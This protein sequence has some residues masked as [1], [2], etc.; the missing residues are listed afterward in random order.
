MLIILSVIFILISSGTLFCVLL[1]NN[2]EHDFIHKTNNNLGTNTSDNNLVNT[3]H[4]TRSNDGFK[5]LE[6]YIKIELMFQPH[7]LKAIAI[8]KFEAIEPLDT[9]SLSL[10]PILYI[11]KINDEDFSN[12]S[13]E[14]NYWDIEITLNNTLASGNII[15]ITIEYEGIIGST[16]P[17]IWN[18]YIGPEGIYLHNPYNTNAS[19]FP[20]NGLAP[21]IIDAIVPKGLTVVC[22]G[23]LLGVAHFTKSSTFAWA[24]DYPREPEV[25][26]FGGLYNGYYTSFQDINISIYLL[27]TE[28][29]WADVLISESLKIL[30]YYFSV[31]SEL[32]IPNLVILESTFQASRGYAVDSYIIIHQQVFNEG[33][34]SVQFTVSHEISHQWFG[35][36]LMPVVDEPGYRWLLEGFGKYA[37]I[38]YQMDNNNSRK[39]LNASIINYRALVNEWL[40][41]FEETPIATTGFEGEEAELIVYG[42]GS[43]VLHMLRYL[44]GDKM[45]FEILSTYCQNFA[46]KMVTLEDF[47]DISKTV[48]Q[49]DLDWFFEQ[50]IYTT[51][52]LDYG[53]KEVHQNKEGVEYKTEVLIER[54]DEAI[55]P[56]D[57]TFY[58]SNNETIKKTKVWNG[59]EKSTNIEITTE[60]KIWKVELDSEFWLLEVNRTNNYYLL[61]PES[62][63]STPSEDEFYF[64]FID[65]MIIIFVAI[66]LMII[67]YKLKK[68]KK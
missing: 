47:I 40:G 22:Q 6:Y 18:H 19:W 51:K 14:R 34:T 29:A 15:N 10:F 43:V 60:I 55:M 67:F 16:S 37:S 33:F 4:N 32:N 45:F 64:D 11:I 54:L 35:H 53:I 27:D 61:V 13:W 12:L 25:M 2:A 66:I 57:I 38:L 44:V 39:W 7:Y 17:M 24:I 41:D 50:W 28:K 30:E 3:E 8:I 48:S 62:T 65:I 20:W 68:S 46:Y 1:N 59:T 9:V 21:I 23:R 31:F 42:K 49:E 5:V 52:H 36:L 26:L 63:V 58:L 56:V